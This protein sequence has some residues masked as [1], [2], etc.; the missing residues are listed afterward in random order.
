MSDTTFT[1]DMGGGGFRAGGKIYD[2]GAQA[3]IRYRSQLE[4]T[5][6]PLDPAGKNYDAPPNFGR[7][8]VPHI[9]T[10]SGIASTLSRSYRNHDE[11][12]RD[13]VANA[14]TMLNDPVIAGPLF[15][16]QRMVSLLNWS[17]ESEDDTDPKLKAAADKLKNHIGKTRIFTE[18]R[19]W[20]SEA[21]W[22]G[23]AAIQHKFGQKKKDGRNYY[24]V[25]DWVPVSGDKLVFRYDDGLGTFDPNGVGIKVSPA[26]ITRDFIAG[27]H[28]IEYFAEGTALFFEY[29]ERRRIAVHKHMIRDGEYE[30]PL[31]GSQVHGVGIRNFLY[32]VWYQKQETLAQLV[33]IVELTSRG[34][35]IYYYPSGNDQYKNELEKTAAAAAHNNVILIPYDQTPGAPSPIE[36]IPPNNSGVQVLKELID[37]F[38]GDM[39]T[40]FI[41]GQTLS[42]KSA[43]TGLGSGVADLHQDSLSQ[44][45]RYDA[46]SLEETITT[47]LL[48]PLRNWNLPEFRSFDFYFRIQTESA[49]PKEQLEAIQQAWQMGAKIKTSEL[50][51]KIGASIPT[52]DDDTVFNPMIRQA[53]DQAAMG[54]GMP[55][56]PPGPM[57]TGNVPTDGDGDGLEGEGGPQ[58]QGPPPGP[59]DEPQIILPGGDGAEQQA[60]GPPDGDRKRK[61]GPILNQKSSTPDKNPSDAQKEAGNYRMG[62]RSIQGLDITIETAKGTRRRP[63][64]PPMPC[65]YGYVKRTTGRDG[66]NVDV[67]IGPHTE[68]EIVYVVDQETAGG[69]YDEAKVMLGFRSQSSAVEAYSLAYTPEWK[70]GTVTSLT[71]TQ[72]K[73]WLE[74]GDTT[75]RIEHQVSR[76]KKPG[77]ARK[78]ILARVR[79]MVD[80]ETALYQSREPELQALRREGD[81]GIPGM[82]D[83]FQP[84]HSGRRKET[85]SESNSGQDRQQRK[86]R[87]GKCSL[88]NSG[89]TAEQPQ[90]QRQN[91]ARR[92]H[93]DN[94]PMGERVG[95]SLQSTP[96]KNPDIWDILRESRYDGALSKAIRY[97]A[98]GDLFGIQR[99]PSKRH[100]S[101]GKRS[102]GPS[103]QSLA[104]AS[105]W[106]YNVGD[107][108]QVD[109]ITYELKETTTGKP[110]WHVYEG[111][112]EKPLFVDDDD[113]EPTPTTQPQGMSLA[114]KIEWQR[115][116]P[117]KG[118][119]ASPKKPSP[120]TMVTMSG[121][122]YELISQ[123]GDGTVTVKN[124]QGDEFDSEPDEEYSIDK[125][126]APTTQRGLLGEDY[127]PAKYEPAEHRE[128]TGMREAPKAKES[129]PVMFDYMDDDPDQGVLF[130]GA[131]MGGDAPHEAY[132]G[133]HA[134]QQAFMD[135]RQTGLGTN[136]AHDAAA[137]TAY[138]EAPEDTDTNNIGFPQDDTGGYDDPY[139]IPRERLTGLTLTTHDSALSDLQQHHDTIKRHQEQVDQLRATQ[140]PEF[141]YGYEKLQN[142]INTHL[143]EI[144]KAERKKKKAW[145]ALQAN[146]PNRHSARHARTGGEVAKGK[147]YKGGQFVAG[148]DGYYEQIIRDNQA[149]VAGIA[150]KYARNHQ[151]REDLMQEGNIGLLEAAHTYDP[152]K[153]ASFG[154][155]AYYKVLGRISN[156]AK[157][158]Y[159]RSAGPLENDPETP[160][161]TRTPAG[162]KVELMLSTLD[163]KDRAIVSDWFGIGTRSKTLE[164]IAN[165]H[166]VSP[167]AI[168]AGIQRIGYRLS[169]AHKY[170][171]RRMTRVIRYAARHAPAGGIT[172]GGQFYP[173]GKFIPGEVW[174]QASGQE[175]QQY[176]TAEPHEYKN[177][178]ELPEGTKIR[179]FRG[180]FTATG[181]GTFTDEKGQE[182]TPDKWFEA[183]AGFNEGGS[184]KAVKEVNK[185]IKNQH[186]EDKTAHF[187]QN[188]DQDPAH[189]PSKYDSRTQKIHGALSADNWNQ[190]D[191]DNQHHRAATAAYNRGYTSPRD[192]NKV[193]S[194]VDMH[195][196]HLTDNGNKKMTPEIKE[197]IRAQ[198]QDHMDKN[199][200][201]KQTFPGA[202]QAQPPGSVK[203]FQQPTGQAQQPAQQA[204]QPAQAPPT[205]QDAPETQSAQDAVN[206]PQQPET[207]PAKPQEPTEQP[208]AR[209]PKLTRNFQ[210]GQ[211]QASMN[212][213]SE[214]QRDLYDY[215][216]NERR[217]MAGK[218]A[219][220]IDSEALAKQHGFDSG[221]DMANRASH[222]YND[223]KDQMKGVK[224]GEH[225]ELSDPVGAGKVSKQPPTQGAG[226]NETP[227]KEGQNIPRESDST[228]QGAQQANTDPV[229]NTGP[230]ARPTPAE[231]AGSMYG[232]PGAEPAKST[233]AYNAGLRDALENM[234]VGAEV[235]GFKKVGGKGAYG[236]S[237]WEHPDGR[238]EM[239]GTLNRHVDA[240]TAAKDHQQWESQQAKPG[241]KGGST[242]R[243]DT[244]HDI[245]MMD[246]AHT[247]GLPP[248]KLNAKAANSFVRLAANQLGY[249]PKGN[250]PQEQASDAV[251]HLK[252]QAPHLKSLVDM[253]GQLGIKSSHGSTVVQAKHAADGII[254][255][256]MQAGWKPTESLE[257]IHSAMVNGDSDAGKE[258]HKQIYEALNSMKNNGNQDHQSL[259]HQ[260]SKAVG[261]QRNLWL[262][263]GTIAALWFAFGAVDSWSRRPS[264]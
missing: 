259:Y 146:R 14:H 213:H 16:R 116:N 182:H 193:L 70:V 114:Q 211:N 132:E 118:K 47:E 4:S 219:R 1:V 237:I 83:Q 226:T 257:N 52:D 176:H 208:E 12:I 173:G 191:K 9:T 148:G 20:L 240:Q 175:Q 88:G 110:R 196:A 124:E 19:R 162:E 106:K 37:D 66:D 46:I 246:A 183:Y 104:Q 29:W 220:S 112:A 239:T 200:P 3:P 167:Q 40:R 41:L 94:G 241:D 256:A 235:G 85:E 95:N 84:I 189:D 157:K 89:G 164:E 152:T 108:K 126:P 199:Y 23:R 160:E 64:W 76:Y 247:F 54:G 122:K 229:S 43:A 93:N 39:I 206:Q 169:K 190:L 215:A 224:E 137:Q 142:H 90:E 67:F 82:D 103:T 18:Y 205:Q 138:P 63:E 72:F 107:F 197:K 238:T 133:Q 17:V 228:G 78:E 128:L 140:G 147:P 125:P 56:M 2:P 260:L 192:V 77:E 255:A 245:E 24:Y 254:Q 172:I 143:D 179:S 42:T 187:A 156:F 221:A 79:D 230:T 33:E 31:S 6:R 13:S 171:K 26:H 212:F 194:V 185:G 141:S 161:D 121:A 159:R 223:V 75:K 144:D 11:A 113:Q 74:H 32:W 73:N 69:R 188:P 36:Q 53:I 22:Y 38:Y 168:H 57:P 127:A 50:M 177:L 10:F 217:R 48:E 154:T 102:V 86:L 28:P 25:K 68:S 81:F 51:D 5:T 145:K 225:R 250:T 123:N 163:P 209:N 184:K 202:P 35:T 178:E 242:G 232:E 264:R 207:P 49:I 27:D 180:E 61:F 105:G 262:L 99:P 91:Y 115:N 120:K 92:P 153:G 234:P 149:L 71:I 58:P 111:P 97:A 100:L 136:E 227:P 44:I 134:Y 244:D 243:F 60:K 55:G 129:Q 236:S 170:D 62:H 201:K 186:Y 181:K 45:V 96:G 195:T 139:N 210:A 21:I 204:Q 59:G 158:G 258:Y 174:A 251:R 233:G 166:G 218:P 131:G 198:I 231:P 101:T 130:A 87:T 15:A 248:S 80:D 222:V 135:A 261:G 151:D 119:G 30:D 216:A 117:G 214:A 253:A 249:K 165:E 252:A 109:G 263:A 7:P 65:D 98:Q 155:H 150:A 8:I 203:P 34:F